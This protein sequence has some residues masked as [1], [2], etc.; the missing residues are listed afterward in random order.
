VT[1]SLTGISTLYYI[2]F[3][4]RIQKFKLSHITVR[5]S[6]RINRAS[7]VEQSIFKS[8]LSKTSREASKKMA[9][10]LDSSDS[11]TVE[12]VHEGCEAATYAP[13]ERGWLRIG[14]VAAASALAGGLAA[15]WFY[16]KTL[17]RLRQAETN[18]HGTE[19]NSSEAGFEEHF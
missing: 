11:A 7:N 6:P 4:R 3:R 14:A 2:S 18:G 8:V 9:S 5:E 19:I 16:R 12:A 13:P 1:A 17:A 10:V 15:A